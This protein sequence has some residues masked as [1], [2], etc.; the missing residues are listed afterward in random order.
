[1]NLRHL[2]AFVAIAETGSFHGAADRLYVTQSAVS[3]QMKALEEQ[4]QVTLFD[5]SARPPVLSVTGR[6]LL[7]RARAVISAAD[8]LKDAANEEEGLFGSLN[9]GVIPSAT[10]S[11]LP[12][13]LASLRD[14]HPRMTVRVEGNLSTALASAVRE[15]TLDAAIITEVGPSGAGLSCQLIYEEAMVLAV[16]V[17]KKANPDADKI[18]RENPFIRFNRGTG[19][20]RVIETALQAC[21]IPVVETME[22]DSIQAMLRMAERGLG[23]AIVPER[24]FRTEATDDLACLPFIGPDGKPV[25]R[26]VGL[27]T[28]HS[29]R[30]AALT[31]ALLKALTE[32]AKAFE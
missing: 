11:I 1:M 27:V 22:L 20:G 18:L 9:L 28:R 10:T 13:A 2:E 14:Q 17:P 24:S 30:D 19:I 4:L 32:A 3:M 21:S 23:A 25:R 15:G 8:A 29:M 31:D 7:E 5:R 6:S 16:K 26:R 12:G